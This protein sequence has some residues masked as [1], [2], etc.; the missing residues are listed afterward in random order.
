MRKLFATG[1]TWLCVITARASDTAPVFTPPADPAPAVATTNTDTPA[2]AADDSAGLDNKHKL[3]PGDV[4]NFRI[5]EDKEPPTTAPHL[6]TVNDSGELDFPYLGLVSVRLKTCRETAA[7]IKAQ[8]EKDYYY[9]A[10]VT[11]ALALQ[12]KSVGRVYLSGEVRA[13][14]P[15]DIPANEQFTAGKAILL[16]G[17]FG[18][19]ADKKHVQVI[20]NVDGKSQIT[21]LNMVEILEKG[22]IEKDMVLQADDFVNVPQKNVVF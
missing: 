11:I 17:G 14:G 2:S 5:L 18:D 22:H 20:R 10:T 21:I 13:T 7:D 8:L 16:S 4:I 3:I 12:T 19:Y 15:K 1:L 6:L 9:K